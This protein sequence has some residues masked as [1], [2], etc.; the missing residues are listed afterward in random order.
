MYCVRCGRKAAEGEKRCAVCNM[1]LVSPAKLNRLL[2]EEKERNDDDAFDRFLISA[3]KTLH[4]CGKHISSGSKK[5]AEA[6]KEKLTL[7]LP[8]LQEAWEKA[9]VYLK[10]EYKVL[11]K[12]YRRLVKNIKAKLA[13]LK[14]TSARENEPR[15]TQ[16][17][18]AGK[19]GSTAKTVG[20]RTSTGKTAASAG[21]V[22]TAAASREERPTTRGELLLQSFRN[23]PKSKN[24]RLKS[25]ENRIESDDYENWSDSDE[26]E[27]AIGRI[28][29]V[30]YKPKFINNKPKSAT[31][32]PKSASA[33]THTTSGRSAAGTVGKTGT[34]KSRS[35]HGYMTREEEEFEE[36]NV[37]SIVSMGCLLLAFILL[38]M[39]GTLTN[40]GRRTFAGL[41]MGSAKGYVLLGDDCMTEGNYSRAVEHYYKALSKKITYDAA[42]KLAAAY[43]HTGDIGRE[44]S[45]LLLCVDYYPKNIEPYK[46]LLYL[47]PEGYER[48]EKVSLALG[49]GLN[50]FGD[51]LYEP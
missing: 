8:K 47:Y 44:V 23:K 34:K 15:M 45:A 42:Y 30:K 40:G 19:T 14:D 10:K 41:G 38:L 33:K 9:R 1:R 50:Q 26:T 13:E 4:S 46:E 21:S 43:S 29:S 11:K 39:W 48:P 17:K 31:N 37:R 18:S 36:K 3:E 16:K 7:L 2:N 22:R 35:A 49:K 5:L 25:A 6:A 20:S 28:E 27:S 24:N 32:R 51:K 12:K